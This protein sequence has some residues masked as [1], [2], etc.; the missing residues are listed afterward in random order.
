MHGVTIKIQND[1]LEQ[2]VTPLSPSPFS[3]S[4]HLMSH[5]VISDKDTDLKIIVFRYVIP[6]SLVGI[7][8]QKG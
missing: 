1:I 2:V 5:L 4:S 3:S 8:R 6:Y 7:C